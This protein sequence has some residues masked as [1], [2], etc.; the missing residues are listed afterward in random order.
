MNKKIIVFCPADSKNMA[1]GKQMEKSLRKFHSEEELPLRFFDNPTGEPIW[2]YRSKP[3]IA[4]QLFQEGFEIVI[5]IDADVLIFDNISSSW[6]GDFDVAAAN[7]SNP[8]DFKNY[9]YQFLN[10]NPLSYVNNG[11]VVIKNPK[12]VDEWFDM[13][14][15]V[16]FNGFQMREQDV[17]NLLMHSNH[18]K[19]KRLDEGDSF[20]NCASKGFEPEIVLKEGKPFLPKG[21]NREKWPDKDK[22]IKAY[23]YAGA[24]DPSKGNYR[25]KFNEE[26]I[27]YI[28]KLL[29]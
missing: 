22:W 24:N 28:E 16:L 6:E 20:W 1:Y 3:I 15:S 2:W 10:I 4:R 14:Y 7:N 5:G 26:M 27:E 9:P 12:F 17:L 18:Y 25:I 19:I 8:R 21:D 23:H 13:C 29:K 11:F